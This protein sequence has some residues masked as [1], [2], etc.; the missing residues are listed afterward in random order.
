MPVDNQSILLT[1]KSITNAPNK[2]ALRKL[3]K[4][5]LEFLFYEQVYKGIALPG[6]EQAIPFEE[7]VAVLH[8]HSS[9]VTIE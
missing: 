1:E 6:K 7:A 4:S 8:P 9:T 2:S 3:M 5:F